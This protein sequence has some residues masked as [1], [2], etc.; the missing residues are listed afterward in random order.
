MV[1]VPIPLKE[2][3]STRES[4]KM[5][6]FMVRALFMSPLENFIPV[7]GMVVKGTAKGFLISIMVTSMK[8]C[9]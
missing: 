1:R 3:I 5:M 6:I 2:E 4:L 9:F 7:N 8:V